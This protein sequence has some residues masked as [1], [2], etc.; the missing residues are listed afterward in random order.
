MALTFDPNYLEFDELPV[1]PSTP[2]S[3][4]LRVYANSNGK[5]A[6]MDDTGTEYELGGSFTGLTVAGASGTP[7][8]IADGQTF[9][10]MGA[11]GIGT[12]A[13]APRTITID[14]ANAGALNYIAH[15][16]LAGI[17]STTISSIPTTYEH[18]KLYIIARTSSATEEFLSLRVGNGGV[19]AIGANYSR[20][21]ITLVNTIVGGFTDVAT[22]NLLVGAS[23]GASGGGNAYSTF[24]IEFPFYAGGEFKACHYTSTA[25]PSA[26]AGDQKYAT[27]RGYWRSVSPINTIGLIG[28]SNFAT[29]SRWILYGKKGAS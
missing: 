3:G 11:G 15:G 1:T 17:S 6:Y 9:T 4:L 13:S 24:I 20:T 19:D 14:G 18:L 28:T 22:A 7:Q 16:S 23:L 27:G 2:A 8:P 10:F 12:T 25:A 21:T 5:L 29:N 26:L